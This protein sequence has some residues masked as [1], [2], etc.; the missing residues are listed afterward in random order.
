MNIYLKLI[1]SILLIL[2]GVVFT[3]SEINTFLVILGSLNIVVGGYILGEVSGII[4][5]AKRDKVKVSK[6]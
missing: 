6:K 3:V 5:T 1:M 4:E 2:S